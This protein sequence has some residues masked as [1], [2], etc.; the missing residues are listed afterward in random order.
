MSANPTEQIDPVK[1]AREL[2]GEG[3]FLKGVTENESSGHR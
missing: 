3:E 1:E 2:S